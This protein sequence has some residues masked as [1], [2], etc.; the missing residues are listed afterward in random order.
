MIYETNSEIWPLFLPGGVIGGVIGAG[1]GVAIN[2]INAN[3][4]VGICTTLGI[5]C[6]IMGEG[7]TA[8]ISESTNNSN[9]TLI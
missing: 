3:P 4:L 1:V 8:T 2:G 7:I 5:L 6:G 9:H